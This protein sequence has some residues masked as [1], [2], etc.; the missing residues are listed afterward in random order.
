VIRRTCAALRPADSVNLSFLFFL[1]ALVI[2]FRRKIG[3]AGPLISLYCVLF[4]LQVLLVRFRRGGGVMRWVYDLIFP[5]LSI[6]L[7]FDSL[8]RIVH[9]INP[10][11]IDPLLIRLDYTIFGFYPTVMLERWVNP[12]LTDVL[13][14]AYSSYY[15][16][17]LTLGVML[18]I[19]KK[20]EALGH[21]LFLIM[22]CFYL[23]YIGYLLMPALG[24]RYTMAHLQHID[25]KGFF[26][27]G[28]IQHMLNG[29]EGI[30]R[31]AFPSGHTAVAITVLYLSYLYARGLFRLFLPCVL[32]LIFSTVYCRYHYVVDVLGG[33]VLAGITIVAGEAYYGYRAKRVDTDR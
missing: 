9:A 23:S 26:V 27:A 3:A 17:P 13:Q 7:I 4:V 12:Y 15:F 24:P 8:G 2:A 25:L 32:A 14:L 18:K 5:T 30:K 20:D 16:L 22:L 33:V 29:L 19:K 6:V 31:D 28:P 1:T 10:R 11:D 21:S